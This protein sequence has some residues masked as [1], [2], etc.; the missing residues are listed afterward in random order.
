[1]RLGPL[2]ARFHLRHFVEVLGQL[3]DVSLE[4]DVAVLGRIF[5]RDEF[6]LLTDCKT[7]RLE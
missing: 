2:I 3:R 5:E 7:I 6:E 4:I 1:M